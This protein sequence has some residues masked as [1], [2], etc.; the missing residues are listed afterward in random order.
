MH[1]ILRHLPKS[2]V[3]EPRD[4]IAMSM[5]FE[6]VCTALKVDDKNNETRAVIAEHIVELSR[7]GERSPTKLR[8]CALAEAAT[9]AFDCTREVPTVQGPV[10]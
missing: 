1:K 7:H 10:P 4:L 3:L 5:A 2:L 9:D 8:D 6:E